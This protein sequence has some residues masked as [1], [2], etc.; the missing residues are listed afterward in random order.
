MVESA[1]KEQET[2]LFQG[3]AEIDSIRFKV[4][5]VIKNKTYILSGKNK[6]T[7]IMLKMELNEYR[8][9]HK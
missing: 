3:I 9:F 6:H 7:E 5:I 1:V 8:K 2:V 4:K